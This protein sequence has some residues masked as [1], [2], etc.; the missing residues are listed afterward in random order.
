MPVILCLYVCLFRT[1]CQ[2]F[3]ILLSVFYTVLLL[4]DSN[5]EHPLCETSDNTEN[6]LHYHPVS[7]ATE[8]AFSPV[9]NEF[10]KPYHVK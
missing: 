10:F 5:D 8:E 9:G 1:L 2:S 6:I 4:D 3:Y 7:R